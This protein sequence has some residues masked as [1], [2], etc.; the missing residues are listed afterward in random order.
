VSRLRR[1]LLGSIAAALLVFGGVADRALVE[2]ATIAEQAELSNLDEKARL[3]ALSVRATLARIEETVL[4]G[5][6]M[7]GVTICQVPGET[8]AAPWGRDQPYAKRP[9]AVLVSLLSSGALTGNGLPEAIVAALALGEA[10]AKMQVADRLLA[11]LLPVRPE[12][13][14][15]LAGALGIGTDPRTAGLLGCLRDAAEPIAA[16]FNPDFNR[17]LTERGTVE[18]RSR[19]GSGLQLYEIAGTTLIEL[20]GVADRAALGQSFADR[21][22]AS[23]RVVNVPD[24]AGLALLVAPDISIP[25]RIQALRI[26]LWIAIATTFLGL[27]TILRAVAREARALAKEKAFLASVSHELRTPLAAIRLFGETLADGRGNPFEYGALVAQESQ[28]LDALVE[29]VLTTARGEEAPSFTPVQPRALVASAVRLV[30]ARAEMRSIRIN[31]DAGD[32]LPEALWDVEAVRRALL[33]LLDNA[34][35]HGKVSG[36]VDVSAVVADGVVK[37]SVSD[38]GPGIRRRDRR[39]VFGRF[40]RGSSDSPGTGLGLYVVEQVARA[41]GGH[42]DLVTEENRGCTFTLV[43]PLRPR[44]TSLLQ[45]TSQGVTADVRN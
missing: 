17:A 44:G 22:E 24:V 4:A 8:R 18:A 32:A 29:Q 25:V 16:G 42:V 45:Q 1:A 30:T 23:D 5:A 28:R 31:S 33:N 3:T 12:D 19:N 2:Q 26:A 38:D 20:A 13:L 15:Y 40:E 39:R 35:K 41:H 27:V 34:I 9:R 6:T 14:P 10:E 11:G 36:R 37:L 43:L 7:P 21:A